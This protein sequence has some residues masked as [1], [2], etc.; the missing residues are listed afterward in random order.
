MLGLQALRPA[1]VFRV[2]YRTRR[3][4]RG[5][6]G[7]QGQ[8][9]QRLFG[10]QALDSVGLSGLS[11]RDSRIVRLERG[12]GRKKGLRVLCRGLAIACVGRELRAISAGEDWR[13]LDD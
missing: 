1:G 5:S 11:G 9:L 2:V 7:S 13:I 3:G 12:R 8:I 6:S 10:H 4:S